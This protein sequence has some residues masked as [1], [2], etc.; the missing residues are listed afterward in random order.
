VVSEPPG[1]K[2]FVADTY[3]GTTPIDFA[4]ER[5]G[6]AVLVRIDHVGYRPIVER[7]V[8]DRDQRLRS[9]LLPLPRK[10]KAPAS[11]AAE[12]VKGAVEK[13]KPEKEAPPPDPYRKFD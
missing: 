13:P 10:T 4:L 1:A 2:V 12:P 7:V 6:K 9:N 3:R 5:G 11:K 8:P